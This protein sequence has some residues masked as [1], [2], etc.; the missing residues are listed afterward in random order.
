MIHAG[1]VVAAGLSQGKSSSMGFDTSWTKFK[2]FR[3]D[4]EKRDFVARL[5]PLYCTHTPVFELWPVCPSNP[6]VHPTLDTM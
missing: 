5:P 6:P 4:H 2:A 1:S 3:N